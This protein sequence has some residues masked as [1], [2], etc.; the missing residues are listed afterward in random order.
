MADRFDHLNVGLF[1][2]GQEYFKLL[3][4]VICYAVVLNCLFSFASQKSEITKSIMAYTRL[5]GWEINVTFQH[6]IGYSLSGP[7]RDKVLGRDLGIVLP[8]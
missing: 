5:V 6:K 7:I 4:S 8:G 2:Y 3:S 1:N